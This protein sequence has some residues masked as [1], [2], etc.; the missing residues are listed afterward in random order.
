MVRSGMSRLGV[1]CPDT[2]PQDLKHQTI[3]EI[4]K[5]Q[6]EQVKK[7]VSDYRH[8]FDQIVE[9]LLEKEKVTGEQFRS[10]LSENPV[11]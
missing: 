1:V 8:I 2:L 7:H 4:V 9:V 10:L 11:Q 3:T 6:E 5:V